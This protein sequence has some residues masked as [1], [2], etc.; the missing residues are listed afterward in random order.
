[1]IRKLISFSVDQP[2]A[3]IVMAIAFIAF[4]LYAFKWL[5]IEAYPDVDDPQVQIFV[6]W[7][8][9]SAEDVESQITL[10]LE[11]AFNSTPK[12]R[13]IRSLSIFGLSIVTMTF[14]DT[15]DINVARS[16]VAMAMAQINL[17]PG[18]QWQMGS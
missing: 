7:P 15:V 6:Q 11:P 18:A 1:M 4:G 14:E 12:L 8:G 5:P 3:M 17:P 13:T 10:Q 16:D 2:L 9:Q